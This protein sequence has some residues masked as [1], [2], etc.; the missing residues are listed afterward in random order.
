[1]SWARQKHESWRKAC[2]SS[3]AAKCE[4]GVAGEGGERRVAGACA[5]Q[6][7]NMQVDAGSVRAQSSAT[8]GIWGGGGGASNV[9]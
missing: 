8:C 7:D 2:A 3:M 1:M 4:D 5:R 6:D 9:R